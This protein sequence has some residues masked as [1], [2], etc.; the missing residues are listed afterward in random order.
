MPTPAEILCVLASYLIGCFAAAYYWTR[1]RTGADIRRFGSGTVGARNAGR[2]LGA[3][4]FAA[5]FLLDFGKGALTTLAAIALQLRPEIVVACAVAVAAGHDW[6]VQ[7]GFRG[8]KGIAV[9][10]GILAALLPQADTGTV[11]LVAALL[12]ALAL[13]RHSQKG[14]HHAA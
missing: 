7:L 1:W 13:F 12:G 5:T 6:P 11:A 9:S 8:G 14:G 3:S 2:V 10:F 4:G